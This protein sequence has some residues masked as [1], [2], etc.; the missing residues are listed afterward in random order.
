MVWL[1]FVK[2]GSEAAFFKS[3]LQRRK[4]GCH[5]FALCYDINMLGLG[6]PQ[7]HNRGLAM[8]SEIPTKGQAY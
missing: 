2:F 1:G 5:L 7:F 3:R 8:R 6:S 4:A